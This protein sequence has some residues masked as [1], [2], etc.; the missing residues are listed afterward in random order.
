MQVT[1]LDHV[2]IV[3]RDIGK[4]I[5]FYEALLGFHAVAIPSAPAGFDGRWLHDGSGQPIIHLQAFD[6]KRHAARAADVP[7]GWIDH[8]AFACEGFEDTKQRC[9]EQGVAYRVNDRQFGT[10]RQIF[11]SDPNN[12]TLELNFAAD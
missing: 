2:N 12:V 9:E 11:V 3:A 1:G 10:L 4:T 7:T 6:P 8:V 5:A